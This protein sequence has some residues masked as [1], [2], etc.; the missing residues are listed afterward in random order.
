MG[1]S[2]PINPI[3]DPP[4]PESPS[5]SPPPQ[6][7]TSTSSSLSSSH[8]HL[9][10]SSSAPSSLSSSLYLPQRSSTI[11]GQ[12]IF[13]EYHNV[14]EVGWET[15]KHLAMDDNQFMVVMSK[16]SLTQSNTVRLTH[17]QH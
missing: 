8:H 11:I 14:D 6:G 13:F 15:S 1:S 7:S 17:M 10:G 5:L 3:V 9:R 16:L 4:L 2:D 12:I